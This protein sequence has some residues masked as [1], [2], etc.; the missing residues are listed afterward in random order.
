M[1]STLLLQQFNSLDVDP[2]ALRKTKSGRKVSRRC[3]NV[4][5]ERKKPSIFQVRAVNDEKLDNKEESPD[6]SLEAPTKLIGL[7]DPGS[8]TGQRK[9]VQGPYRCR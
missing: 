4:N 2:T 6:A 5:L 3:F 1:N 7:S 8:L 9:K